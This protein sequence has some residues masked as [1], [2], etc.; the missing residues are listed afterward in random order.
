MN[1]LSLPNSNAP[2]ERIWSELNRQK[3]NSRASLLYGTIRGILLSKQYIKD[4]E[5]LIFFEPKCEMF[6]RMIY[7]LNNKTTSKL[8]FR[9]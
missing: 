6:V 5:G 2:S 8:P 4:V 7:N 9:N 3:D 1:V